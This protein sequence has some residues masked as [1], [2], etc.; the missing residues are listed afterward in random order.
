MSAGVLLDRKLLFEN[1][2]VV[3]TAT[4]M[5][6]GS[7]RLDLN[8]VPTEGHPLNLEVRDGQVRVIAF[9][10][11]GVSTLGNQAPTAPL[12]DG[13]DASK[14]IRQDDLPDVESARSHKSHSKEKV[15]P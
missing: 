2:R 15:K 3:G 1:G 12:P 5:G 13:T 14:P 8:R 4:D 10:T 11:I 9:Q 7:V 6:N